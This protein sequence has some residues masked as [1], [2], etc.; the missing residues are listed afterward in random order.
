M[1]E[2]RFP[3]LFFWIFLLLLPVYCWLYAG[4]GYSDTDEGFIHGLSYRILSGET[5]YTDFD[6]VRPPLTPWLHAA[7]L[8]LLP[9]YGEVFWSR[10]LQYVTTWFSVLLA[11][12]SILRFLPEWKNNI[13]M[14]AC[15]I[16]ILD[17]HNAPAMP[18][19]T[20]D[21]IF[22]S[23]L[24]FFLLSRG[25]SFA[26][27]ISGMTGF[28]LAALCKQSFYLMPFAGLFFIYSVWGFR[29]LALSF[30]SVIALAGGAFLFI[31]F[32][33]P[34]WTH[35][36]ITQTTFH[37][38][39]NDF[40]SQGFFEYLKPAT[41]VAVL[42]IGLML[43]PNILDQRPG[44]RKIAAAGFLLFLSALLG[45]N[46][47]MTFQEQAF[48]GL[49]LG[50]GQSLFLFAL[51]F[52]LFMPG[53]DSKA[54]SVLGANLFLTWSAAI[55]W[56]YPIP[57]RHSAP[58]MIIFLI[59]FAWIYGRQ[60]GEWIYTWT[61]IFFLASFFLLFQFPYRDAPRNQCDQDG[62]EIFP[63][64]AFHSI[65]KENADKLRELKQLAI[66]HPQFTVMPAMP[67]AHYLTQTQ[68]PFPWDWE[69]NAEVVI[70]DTQAV[71]NQFLS[72]SQGSRIAVFVQKDHTIEFEREGK[73][74]TW[75]TRYIR[76][77]WKKEQETLY[78]EVWLR[79]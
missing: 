59:G 61:T 6:Y 35:A 39:G 32:S 65:G 5:I 63:Q 67:Q 78:F 51:A 58:M 52:L 14:L 42:L 45:L 47:F 44:F 17:C 23:S 11:L 1:N 40:I 60:I 79:P 21:G 49:V 50:W 31:R 46:I 30:L 9:D 54:K 7:E 25:P 34:E 3:N 69:H 27:L 37:T 2:R 66:S 19:H 74:G 4:V 53:I 56:G 26:W 28:L 70:A 10:C 64:L 68:N 72:P 75:L 15:G 41:A 16:F 12:F 24:G 13:W 29:S 18:W 8:Q 20:T 62:G 55:S 43:W 71:I 48:R 57:V 38:E 36:W 22:F 73:Y 77:H 33:A 76:A